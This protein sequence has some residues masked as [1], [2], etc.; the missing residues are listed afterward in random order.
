MS[1]TTC[2]CTRV[3]ETGT[4]PALNSFEFQFP[5]HKRFKRKKPTAHYCC[6]PSRIFNAR[7]IY[8]RKYLMQTPAALPPLTPGQLKI[9]AAMLRYFTVGLDREADSLGQQCAGAGCK[10]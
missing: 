5:T 7:G 10:A 4:D 6:R 3:L 9:F 8:I 2:G 1:I